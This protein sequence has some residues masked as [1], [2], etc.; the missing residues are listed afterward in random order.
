MTFTK[1][2]R[3]TLP[4]ILLVVTVPLP[5]LAAPGGAGGCVSID[6]PDAR[7]RCY[8]ARLGRESEATDPEAVAVPAAA[9]PSPAVGPAVIEARVVEVLTTSLG[10]TRLRLDNG[11]T[12]EYS[13]IER[14][15]APEPDTAVV[16]REGAFGSHVLR[17]A[18]GSARS[19]KVRR[20][21]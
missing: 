7:L 11:E 12:W 16:I 9:A 21:R 18:D 19:R 1:R 15:P 20:V 3:N 17:P 8:D 4:L 10:R 6:D 14:T 2:S 5:G 13:R